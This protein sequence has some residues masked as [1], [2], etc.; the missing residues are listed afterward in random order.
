MGLNEAGFAVMNANSYN[1][2]DILVD[3]VDDGRIMRM[4]LESCRNLEDFEQIL[5]ETSISGRKDCW[6]FGA[7][8]ASGGVAMYECANFGYSKFDANDSLNEGSG[9]I[10]RATFSLSGDST[11]DGFSRYKRATQ[12]VAQRLHSQRIDVQFILQTLARD[13]TNP[14]D[15]PYPLPYDGSQNS[16]PAGFILA[17]DVTINRTIS[18]SL[19]V[20][21]GVAPGEDPCLSTV[22]GSIGQPALTVAYPM[23]VRSHSVPPVLNLGTQVPMYT[24]VQRRH[25]R[26]YS[27][28][29]D[30]S[31]LNSRYLVGKNGIGL[32]T[33]TLP[34]ETAVLERVEEYLYDW[35]IDTP[36]SDV[37][38]LVQNTI[39]DSI[40]RS[41]SQIPLDFPDVVLVGEPT[42]PVAVKCYPNPFNASTTIELTGFEDGEQVDV[43][44]FSLLGQLMNEMT[45]RAIDG[46][47]AT[48]DGTD[49]DGR[50]LSSGVYFINATSSRHTATV[51]TILIK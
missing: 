9:V 50:P 5:N 14:I 20:I 42:L 13:L 6:N 22:W 47:A 10:I 23:W 45:L 31:Y 30:E 40:F 43:R 37:F 34:L 8:D 1:L 48:W 29:N 24:E 17:Q 19:L 25:E 35:R 2:N 49:S 36:N 16:R 38:A 44:F 33:Y 28:R 21:Q 27:L 46:A 39:A 18:R 7:I 41:Y 12:L 4:A 51:K 3:G 26:L 15:D 11:R 32:F